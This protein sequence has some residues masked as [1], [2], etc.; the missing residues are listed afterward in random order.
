LSFLLAAILSVII[1]FQSNI[2]NE[3]FKSLFHGY[4]I[5]LIFVASSCAI[6][7]I[8]LCENLENEVSVFLIE[9]IS[10]FYWTVL[11]FY[12]LMSTVLFFIRK[13]KSK[14]SR[15]IGYRMVILVF[16]T[17]FHIFHYFIVQEI[18]GGIT[19]RAI[20]SR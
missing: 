3:F 19:A 17:I 5:L 15:R 14:Q 4:V 9:V 8:V 20:F 6:L 12:F 16:G 2:R 11:I 7:T 13:I 18:S 1:G 10:Y